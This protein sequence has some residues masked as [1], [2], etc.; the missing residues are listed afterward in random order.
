MKINEERREMVLLSMVVLLFWRVRVFVGRENREV[1]LVGRLKC[2]WVM[3]LKYWMKV[4]LGVG[5]LLI[6]ML[7]LLW[8]MFSMMGI[9]DVRVE[10]KLRVGVVR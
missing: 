8:V 3:V 4:V 5:G 9:L 1:E 7:I 6:M 10:V 2:F